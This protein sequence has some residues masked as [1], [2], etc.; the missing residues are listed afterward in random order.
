MDF[1]DLLILAALAL[2]ALFRWFGNQSKKKQTPTSAPPVDDRPEYVE[3]EESEF[4]RAIREIG[5][6]LGGQEPE[7]RPAERQE[8]VPDE[9][10]PRQKA[11]TG[12]G[13]TREESFER[14]PSRSRTPAAAVPFKSLK[15]AR[16][17]TPE[18]EEVVPE[19]RATAA[20]GVVALLRAR[21]SARDAVMLSEVLRPPLALR[22]QSPDERI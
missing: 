16:I 22:R 4:A 10:R 7:S 15:L 19:K 11:A 20:S 2:P 21:H 5:E 17:E 9:F 1:F 13:F 8:Y 3:A 14:A 18:L 6:A 12:S